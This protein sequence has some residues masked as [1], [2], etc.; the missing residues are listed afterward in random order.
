M[1]I[2]FKR[3]GNENIFKIKIWTLSLRCIA[4]WFPTYSAPCNNQVTDWSPTAPGMKEQE[5]LV[6]HE[7]QVGSWR[8]TGSNWTGA[9]MHEIHT[10]WTTTHS[11]QIANSLHGFTKRKSSE[12]VI[13]VVALWVMGSPN[14]SL[15]LFFNQ[16]MIPSWGTSQISDLIS[17][18]TLGVG[19]SDATCYF[20]VLVAKSCP[21]LCDPMDCSP[22]DPSVHGISQARIQEWVAISISR[23]SSQARD[24][25]HDSCIGRWVLYH[26]AIRE[27]HLFIYSIPKPRFIVDL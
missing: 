4:I 2:K 7:S 1:D 26:W 6:V 22:P 12:P 20:V 17:K 25:T 27:T 11:L 19:T 9:Q 15:M 8:K 23:G 14:A 10:F 13:W 16:H 18:V 24:Q 21:T 5:I 3:E